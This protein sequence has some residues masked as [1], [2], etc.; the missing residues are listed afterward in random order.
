[1]LGQSCPILC[2]PMDYN[3]PG[4]SVLGIFQAKTLEWV[5]YSIQY[6]SAISYSIQYYN[7]IQVITDLSK[8]REYTP[9]RV[10]PSVGPW[11]VISVSLWCGVLILAEDVLMCGVRDIYKKLLIFVQFCHEPKTAL[12]KSISK[13]SCSC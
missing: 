5:S 3:M 1:M 9:S 4:S 2:N 10:N 12:K 7:G 8:L 11:I 6:Y 13:R